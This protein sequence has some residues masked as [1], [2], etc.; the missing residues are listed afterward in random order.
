MANKKITQGKWFV[1]TNNRH[2]V[3][4]ENGSKI[5]IVWSGECKNDYSDTLKMEA[6]TELIAL[7]GNLAQK[8]NL[9]AMEDCVKALKE[10]MAE[11]PKS[12]AGHTNPSWKIINDALHKL[13]YDN[14]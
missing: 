4:L 3:W 6:N 8:Y 1:N 11:V 5:A 2:D 12:Y 7:A 13:L 10:A 9:E 14:D